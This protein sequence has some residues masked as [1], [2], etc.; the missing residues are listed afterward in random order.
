MS[1]RAYRVALTISLV[2]NVLLI[3]TIA[4]YIHFE[5]LLSIIEDAIGFFG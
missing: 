3:A 5:G 4:L 1:P 2:V